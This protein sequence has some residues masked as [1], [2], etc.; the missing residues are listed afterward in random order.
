M[1]HELKTIN[2]YFTDVWEGIKTFELR[3]NDRGFK[4]GDK[5]LLREYDENK[6]YSFREISATVSYVLLGGIYGLS[7][8]FCILSLKSIR[9]KHWKSLQTT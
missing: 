8:G 7:E 3:K 6:G 1:R 4:N 9:C 5:L 2:P